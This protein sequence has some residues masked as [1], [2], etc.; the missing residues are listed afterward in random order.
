MKKGKC[1]PCVTR[2]VTVLERHCQWS[3]PCCLLFYTAFF[4]NTMIYTFLCT[5]TYYNLPFYL[6]HVPH[7]LHVS[8]TFYIILCVY[9]FYMQI[10]PQTLSYTCPI[11]GK[12]I[13]NMRHHYINAL[14]LD[15][16]G[17]GRAEPIYKGRDK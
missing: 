13:Y 4:T 9:M 7:I 15:C 1:D 17:V 5:K 10:A 8:F 2:Q 14:F 6:Y 3:I 12:G 16:G 11:H